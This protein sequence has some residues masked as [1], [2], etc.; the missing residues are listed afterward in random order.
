M[1]TRDPPAIE[2]RTK[3][4]KHLEFA[5]AER[6][7]THAGTR[8]ET[9]FFSKTAG[10]SITIGMREAGSHWPPD[11]VELTL[12]K[13]KY[14]WD[15]D[16][17]KFDASAPCTYSSSK[18]E[19]LWECTFKKP[20]QAGEYQARVVRAP[21]PTADGDFIEE[22]TIHIKPSAPIVHR[23][24]PTCA[25]SNV[26]EVEV[27][28]SDA[29]G[30]ES[31]RV[32]FT[33]LD[34]ATAKESVLPFAVGTHKG[35]SECKDKTQ[36]KCQTAAP[37]KAHQQQTTRYQF[38]LES[39]WLDRLVSGSELLETSAVD[40]VKTRLKFGNFSPSASD[41]QPELAWI[42]SPLV[43]ERAMHIPTDSH[44]C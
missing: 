26:L 2:W 29:V 15:P 28:T 7:I 14:S 20:A 36:S 4:K 39:A 41:A 21:N 22:R 31:V 33:T 34:S 23:L 6:S 38:A 16:A 11:T 35:L 24:R 37:F 30:L 13:L 3:D 32:A 8:T 5:P 44:G 17:A 27:E 42:H 19:R 1:N 40:R 25:S 18:D 43:I 10:D 9:S 12:A